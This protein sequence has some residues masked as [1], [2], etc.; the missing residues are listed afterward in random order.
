MSGRSLGP[1]L[2][3]A[4][5]VMAD[6]AS[7]EADPAP[8]GRNAAASSEAADAARQASAGGR[9][10]CAMLTGADI[11][12]VTGVPIERTEKQ[13]DGC[14]WYANAA[15]QQQ[16]GADIARGTLSSLMKQEPKS[17]TESALA[18]ENL[19]KGIGGAVQPNKPLFAATVHWTGGDQ[20]EATF[21]GTTAVV[22]GGQQGGALE[23]IEGLGDR[24]AIGAMGMLFYVRKGPTL[25]LFGAMG[26]TRDQ[27][28]ALARKFISKL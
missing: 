5:I 28:I 13:T 21:K 19:M 8:P 27:E 15:A 12:E 18:M 7:K 24:A 10:V 2:V 3:C 14:E 16:K 1:W 6:C 17:A 23:P 4:C 11:T 22:A 9:D 26:I 20:A 25:V